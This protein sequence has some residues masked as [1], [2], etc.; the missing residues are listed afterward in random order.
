MLL[1]TTLPKFYAGNSHLSSPI[2]IMDTETKAPWL[3]QKA[4]FSNYSLDLENIIKLLYWNS[5]CWN[6]DKLSNPKKK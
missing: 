2:S 1:S 5:S 6:R 3:S 4:F